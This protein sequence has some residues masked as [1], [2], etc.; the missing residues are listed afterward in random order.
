MLGNILSAESVTENTMSNEGTQIKTYITPPPYYNMGRPAPEAGSAHTALIRA[1]LARSRHPWA[2][3]GFG[4][5]TIPLLVSKSTQ[6]ELGQFI[7]K[8]AQAL[9]RRDNTIYTCAALY[10]PPK[11]WH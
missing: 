7:Y 4:P 2:A 6:R 3:R 1:Q 10:C 9:L 11:D 8:K 5:R